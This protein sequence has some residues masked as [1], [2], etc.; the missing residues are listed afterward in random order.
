MHPEWTWAQQ[1]S[2]SKDINLKRIKHVF[3]T[4]VMS[5]L[6]VHYSFLFC[7][8]L[9]MHVNFAVN[10][11]FCSCDLQWTLSSVYKWDKQLFFLKG[12]ISIMYFSHIIAYFYLSFYSIS[13]YLF[14]YDLFFPFKKISI[15]ILVNHIIPFSSRLVSLPDLCH[16]PCVCI[17]IIIYLFIF[18]MEILDIK[19]TSANALFL[20]YFSGNVNFSLNFFLINTQ[21]LTGAIYKW[22]M[23]T[24]RYAPL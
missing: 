21:G 14:I 22:I 18:L 20:W 13:L 1:D 23:S 17:T 19:C 15:V 9:C 16:S 6:A 4:S 10:F 2:G 3:C 12:Y 8:S 11:L 7:L 24:Y 5:C